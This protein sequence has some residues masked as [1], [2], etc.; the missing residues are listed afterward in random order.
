MKKVALMLVVV[1][2]IFLSGCGGYPGGVEAPRETNYRTGSQGLELIFH[3]DTPTRLYENDEARFFVEIRNKG[4][5][6]QYDEI[7]TLG[8]RIWIGG[9][10][11]SVLELIPQGG[12][13]ELDFD[14]LEGKSEVNLEGGYS[15]VIIEGRT[16]NLP[17]GT[18]FYRTPIIVTTTYNYKTIATATVCIDP[19]PRSPNVREKVCRVS[20]YGSVS[21]SGSQGAPVAVT[22]IEEDVTATSLLF[23]IYVQN[24]GDGL[25]IEENDVTE[26]PNKGYDWDSLDRVYIGDV[27]VGNMD[28][29]SCR[30]GI[31]EYVQLIDGRGYIF[32]KLSS[33]SVSGV[34]KAPLN[35]QLEYGYSNS[36]QRDI[37]IFRE[38]NY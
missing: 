17:E 26:D 34:Y 13:N 2:V 21:M 30:P 15:A 5:F 36:I 7:G 6:P 11:E 27:K 22:S 12:N 16:F 9:H 38:L 1:I 3:A 33:S 35:I 10:D 24:V 20:E 28:M 4:A 23:K 32:C 29:D 14:A 37:E 31:K 8:G 25:I 18:P 19:N